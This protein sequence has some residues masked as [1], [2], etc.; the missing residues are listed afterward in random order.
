M[1]DFS[2][3]GIPISTEKEDL[4]CYSFDASI[5]EERLPHAVAWPKNT[6]DVAR[7][8]RFAAENNL[9][10]IPR[11]AGTGM[12]GGSVPPQ[13]NCIVLSFEKM[14]KILDVDTRNMT[15]TVEPGVV[16]SQLQKE[17]EY[18][19]FFYPPDPASLQM[20]TIGG[21]VAT[22]AGGP[23]A[24]KYGVTRD[25]V[26][27]IEA[28]LP[29]GSVISTGGKTYKRAV[30]YD[31]KDLLVGSEGTLAI[32]TRIRL[33]IVPLPEDVMTLLVLF[34]SVESAG[35]AVTKILASRI[36][37]RTM[38]FMDRSSIEAIEKYKPTGLPSDVEALLLIELDGYPGTIR[39]EGERLVD[40]CHTLGGEAIV[41][42]DETARQRL[43]DARRSIS[44]A[45]YHIKSSKI[46]EDIVVPRDKLPNILAELKRISEQSGIQ[47]ISF[48]HA[49]DGN[50]HV[51]VMADIHNR[52]EKARGMKA[53]EEI[54][55]VTLSL[56]G[57]ISGEH[58]IGMT[59][60]PY[61]GME[62]K[63]REMALMRGIKQVFDPRGMLNP[64]KIFE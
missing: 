27:G 49:G 20:C 6:D 28:V 54:F 8:V 56:G 62:I 2:L 9:S 39:K 61:I 42:E 23:R 12:A 40:I 44:P 30:G 41:A 43:W 31:L 47:I 53:V 11:G 38:E 1:K 24:V 46:N 52:E 35:Q 34:S 51:N 45:L 64:K 63:E 15:V 10:V 36:T 26:M 14:R 33:K 5:A 58:G 16:N 25:Y 32:S 4:I 37:P 22:N 48:G 60:T 21:N 55:R 59:K 50:L 3:A 17:M 29:D 18:L 7:I 57:A 19:G 13:D